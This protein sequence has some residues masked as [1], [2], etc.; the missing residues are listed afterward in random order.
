MVF[1]DLQSSLF[2]LRDINL[3]QFF[4]LLKLNPVVTLYTHI[5]GTK[6]KCLNLH[7]GLDHFLPYYIIYIYA[8][9]VMLNFSC[10]DNSALF[11]RYAKL[12]VIFIMVPV[13]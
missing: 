6:L 8:S 9:G 7:F 12:F 10:Y 11:R 5:D 13:F 2:V 3:M 4:F 1:F